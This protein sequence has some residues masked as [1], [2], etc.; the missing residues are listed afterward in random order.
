MPRNS[1]GVYTLPAGNPVVPGT[2]IETTWANPTMADIADALTNSLP[3]DGSAPMT[4]PLTL[5]SGMPTQPR[6]A[7]SKEYVDSFLAYA[8]GMP[9]GF[10]AAYAAGTAPG[11]WLKCDGSAVSRTTYAALFNLIGTSYGAGDNSTTFNLP[12][13]RG[14]FI[15][16]RSDSR[17]VGSKQAGS[18]GSHTHPV[19]DPGH[20]HMASQAAHSHTVTTNP[21]T[22]GVT[23]PGHRHGIGTVPRTSDYFGPYQS[24][25]AAETNVLSTSSQTGISIQ[26]TGNVGGTTDAATPAVTVASATTGLSVGASG[27]AETVP[28]NMAL[29]YYIKAIVDA[30][31]PTAIA[32]IASS[33]SNMIAIDNSNPAIPELDIKSN[34]AFGT[35]KLDSMGKVPLGQMPVENT[36]LLGFFDASTG[37]NPSEEYPSKT[38]TNGDEYVVSVEGTID[39]Y[40]PVTL[41]HA[42]TL[43]G[44]GS[45]L[46][47]ISGSSS[48]PTGWYT[49]VAAATTLASEVAFLPEGTIT[50]T[51]VQDAIAELD[52]DI[53]RTADLIGFT[54]SGTIVATNVQDAIEEL[55]AEK[56]P[57]TG[58]TIT[59]T[60]GVT[61]A[62]AVN[63]YLS[64]QNPTSN[65]ALVIQ[66]HGDATAAA[67]LTP[68]MNN[69]PISGQSLIAGSGGAD[70]LFQGCPQS[71]TAPTVAA[72]LTRK[73]YVDGQVATRLPL[74]GGTLTGNLTIPNRMF[75]S[76]GPFSVYSE[77][78]SAGMLINDGWGYYVDTSGNLNVTGNV[79]AYSDIRLKT[80][81]VKIPDALNKVEQLTGY[82]YQRIDTKERQTGLVAQDVQKVLPEAVLASEDGTLALAYGNLVG[83]LVEAIK[84][85]KAEVKELRAKVEGK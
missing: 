24:N 49:I 79:T 58:G 38:F 36:N 4:G 64:T 8:T 20:A 61:G 57:T 40:D 17:A 11:G 43:V 69:V 71:S 56:F 55:D 1:Q 78:T 18:L 65:N 26:S 30:D 62:V 72:S 42:P 50:A 35:V 7:T 46:L 48:N 3:R 28:Q 5:A 66:G 84:E 83:L 13:L 39:V 44:V 19:S 37:N 12:D 41:T 21:H 16:G 14:E 31:G 15:R 23:D 75:L 29:D 81:L 59:G 53:P 70:W 27:G 22:H 68:Y 82:T 54:P 32:G 63:G 80:D 51:N 6:H 67:I 25:A 85:L 45:T 73:D 74:A 34:V 33:D 60:L 52:G 2:L 76:V 10:I 9:V 77:A 47:Y